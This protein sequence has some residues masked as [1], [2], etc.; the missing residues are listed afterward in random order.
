ML[1]QQCFKWYLR[2]KGCTVEDPLA[3]QLTVDLRHGQGEGDG[4]GVGRW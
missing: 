1:L 3:D 2:F 4:E